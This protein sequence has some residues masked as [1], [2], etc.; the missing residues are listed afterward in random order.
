M[1]HLTPDE[2]ADV[3]S[4]KSY[5]VFTDSRGH[6]LNLVGIRTSDDSANRFN[7]YFAV[8]Y[9]YDQAWT[10]FLF[11]ITTDP[12][13]YWRENPELVKGTAIVK[14]GQYRSAYK[15]GRHRRYKALQ[16]VGTITVFRDA[17]K[18][19]LLDT[20][21]VDEDSGLHAI[22][23]HRASATRASTQVDKWSAGCQVFQDPDHFLFLLALCEKAKTKFGNSFSYTL[24]E[25]SDFD[26]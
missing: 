15:I 16:Q 23:I 14:P 19:R 20:T 10:H 21:G 26:V 18:D 8:F 7:D 2:I 3:M 1:H 4:S 9:R 12:G 11:P 6:D 13:T 24:L 22:N 5:T 17:N 25:D